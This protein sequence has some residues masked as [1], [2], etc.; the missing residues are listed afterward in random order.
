MIQK[1]NFWI[2]KPK[3]FTYGPRREHV[4]VFLTAPWVVAA[5]QRQSGYT[6]EL[7]SPEKWASSVCAC[8]LVYVCLNRF[9]ARNWLLQ[10]RR[11]ASQ[12]S[13]GWAGRLEIRE[14]PR[15]QFKLE[16]SLLAEFPIA[17]GEVRFFFLFFCSCL[18]LIG[19]GPP[20]LWRIIFCTQNLPISLLISSETS[21]A[22]PSWQHSYKIIMLKFNGFKSWGIASNKHP[23]KEL[24]VC[25]KEFSWRGFNEGTPFDG[26]QQ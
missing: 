8:V 6:W 4:C 11:P 9:I 25:S 7:G 16:G 17:L 18:Q 21:V 24:M 23:N 14:E 15:T 10:L 19:P 3:K 2:Y 13:A 5:N 26:G 1:F 12:K 22:E 20:T